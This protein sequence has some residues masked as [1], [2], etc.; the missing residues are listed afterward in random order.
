MKAN[1]FVE[2]DK[3]FRLGGILHPILGGPYGCA[4]PLYG[5]GV[6]YEDMLANLARKVKYVAVRPFESLDL[7]ATN[8]FQLHKSM[9]KWHIKDSLTFNRGHTVIYPRFQGDGVVYSLIGSAAWR[10]VDD[11]HPA[12]WSAVDQT[13]L[14]EVIKMV[15]TEYDCGKL[16]HFER[17]ALDFIMKIS[18]KDTDPGICSYDIYLPP[19]KFLVEHNVELK[20]RQLTGWEKFQKE[21]KKRE[22]YLS[23]FAEEL[24][25]V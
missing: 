19:Q 25:R 24:A 5:N 14:L 8:V 1:K 23:Q 7:R 22:R 4:Y 15:R 10:G 11:R 20:T 6:T 17:W 12:N 2:Y 9:P 3:R 21:A 18:W 16:E 13:P